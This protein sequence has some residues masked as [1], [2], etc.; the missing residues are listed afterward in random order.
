M[1]LTRTIALRLLWP[2]A[3]CAQQNTAEPVAAASAGRPIRAV[4]GGSFWFARRL[5]KGVTRHR[6]GEPGG[7]RA[8]AREGRATRTRQRSRARILKHPRVPGGRRTCHVAGARGL[9]PR[10]TRYLGRVPAGARPLHSPCAAD[11][12]ASWSGCRIPPSSTTCPNGS[13]TGRRTP[14][15]IPRWR[16][17]SAD[18]TSLPPCRRGP[19]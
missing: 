14:R 1:L 13:W 6:A 16:R 15:C 12:R 8:G 4:H 10:L 17:P 5:R 11:R 2:L 3:P 9:R 18:P 19:P 7:Y